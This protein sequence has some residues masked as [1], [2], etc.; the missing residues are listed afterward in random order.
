[1]PLKCSFKAQFSRVYMFFGT[2]N[3][4]LGSILKAEVDLMVFLYMF[5]NKI[6]K[7]GG[8]AFRMQFEGLIS[9][10]YM[11]FGTM[12]MNLR[13]ILKPEVDIMVLLRMR[14]NKITTTGGNAFKMQFGGL[15][16]RVCM[17]VGTTNPNLR[18]I[19]KPEVALLVLLHMR[20]DKI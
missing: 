14:S 16:S 20:S 1:M 3:P 5:S 4:N 13:P 18:S 2:K 15:N 10:V 19:L 12:N 17:F 6:T 7:N 9:R 11:S 8:N